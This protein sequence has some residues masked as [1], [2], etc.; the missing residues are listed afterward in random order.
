[1][2]TVTV[3]SARSNLFNLIKKTITEHRQFRVV[4][5]GGGAVLLSE[6]D[7]DNL[8]ETLELLSTPGLLKSIRKAKREIRKGQTYSMKDVFGA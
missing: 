8:I 2:K 1:M 5:R 6:N 3:T 7:Y 4:S